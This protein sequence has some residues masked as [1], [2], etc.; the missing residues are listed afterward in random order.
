MMSTP[1][2]WAIARISRASCT[3][4]FSVMMTIFSRSSL[5]LISSATPSRTPEGGR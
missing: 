3:A 2:A 4:I 5:T 1:F